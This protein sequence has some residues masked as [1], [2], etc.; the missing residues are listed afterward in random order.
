MESVFRFYLLSIEFVGVGIWYCT[1]NWTAIPSNN[2]LTNGS[3]QFMS[4]FHFEQ[5]ITKRSGEKRSMSDTGMKTVFE[6]NGGDRTLNSIDQIFQNFEMLSEQFPVFLVGYS[7][8]IY[9]VW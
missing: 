1:N 6:Q 5:N 2:Q 3:G 4:V 8:Y 7:I 9:N